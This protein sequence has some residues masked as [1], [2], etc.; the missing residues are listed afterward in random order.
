[1][2]GQSVLSLPPP[3]QPVH[4]PDPGGADRMAVIPAN[5]PVPHTR[6]QQ[7]TPVAPH[8]SPMSPTDAQ[9]VP[10]VQTSSLV[11]PPALAKHE[12]VVSDRDLFYDTLNKFHAALG[13]RL[14]IPTIGGKE[15]DLHMLYAEVS[16]RGGLSQ[17]I[18]DRK[19]KE[20]TTAFNFPP[21]TTSA[22]YVLRKYYISLV[23][24]YEQ[25]YFFGVQG[26]LVAPP[27]PVLTPSPVHQTVDN[28]FSHL[29]VE[30]G[31]P[32]M[33]RKK[34]RRVTV[35][36]VHLYGV[37]PGTHVGRMVTGVI[38][39]KFEHGYLVTVVVGSEK[40]KGVLYHTPSGSSA[41]Q[42]ALVPGLIT[43]VGF[44]LAP[45]VRQRRRRR[46][47]DEMPKRDPNAPKPN[48]SGY[49]FFF[50]EQHLRLKALYPDK[51]KE[52]SR[53][54]GEQWNKLTE[55]E[56]AV[57]QQRGVEDKERYKREMA[58]YQR[59]LKT[60]AYEGSAVCMPEVAMQPVEDSQQD[61]AGVQNSGKPASRLVDIDMDLP[62]PQKTNVAQMM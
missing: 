24:H 37:N 58:E 55:D 6:Q 31:K 11:Y 61:K 51:D 5:P 15:L 47:K 30:E 35:D 40:L 16:S 50:Q 54:I 20:V 4:S 46:R 21:T 44:T 1:M 42:F 60:Q 56:K 7:Q 34:R 48:R 13:T 45:D 39:G 33:N 2:S 29:G 23:H 3:P 57:Y 17:V 22:S 52:I 14:M 10:G 59:R 32:V 18:R 9:A 28:G 49:N 26:Q 36:P 43:N 38:D 19:W 8:P 53:M 25:V 27:A 62:E 12:A 41:A